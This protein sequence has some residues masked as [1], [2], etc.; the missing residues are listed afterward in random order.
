[1]MKMMDLYL[2]LCSRTFLFLRMQ[3]SPEH[4]EYDLINIG[5]KATHDGV[6]HPAAYLE[7]IYDAGWQDAEG[8]EGKMLVFEKE[9]QKISLLIH[10]DYFKTGKD[11]R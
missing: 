8:G 6:S 4:I 3:K 5:K 2:P 10:R 1:M 9:E 7:K 11:T